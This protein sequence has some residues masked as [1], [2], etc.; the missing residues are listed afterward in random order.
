[1]I[2]QNN[3]VHRFIRSTAFLKHSDCNV[4]V[5]DWGSITFAPYIWASDRVLIVGKFAAKMISFLESKELDE[6]NLTVVGH[7]LGAHVAG[8]ASYYATRRANYVV[9][10]CTLHDRR[11]ITVPSS[12]IIV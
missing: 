1:M 6:K 3:H 5:I 11:N 7:S 12:S 8:L 2:L 9:R 4:I 10:E